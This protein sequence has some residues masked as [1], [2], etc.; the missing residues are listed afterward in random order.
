M[1]CAVGELKM[2]VAWSSSGGPDPKQGP[3]CRV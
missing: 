1:A 3:V 2:E